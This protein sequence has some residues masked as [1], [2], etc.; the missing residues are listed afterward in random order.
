MAGGFVML[1]GGLV[2]LGWTGGWTTLIRPL[3][4]MVGM[5]PLT[6]LLLVFCGFSLWRLS[7]SPTASKRD[8]LNLGLAGAV[9]V[10]G[11][12]RSA[13]YL[14][15]FN[16]HLEQ[17]LFAKRVAALASSLPSE[18]AP[19]T[20]VNLLLCGVALL[21]L[22]VETPRR[23]WFAQ[24]LVLLSGMVALLALIGYTY[25][26]LVFYQVGLAIPMSLETAV[27]FAALCLGFLA[28]RPVGGFMIVVT[29][30][31]TGGTVIRRLLP[32]A[33]FAPWILGALLL[34]GEQAGRFTWDIGLSI[35][36]VANIVIF[37][38]LI[39]WNAKLLFLADLERARAEQRRAVQHNATRVL[40]EASD[41]REATPRLLQTICE[42]L[43]WQGAALWMVDAPSNTLRCVEFWHSPS[44]PLD[45]F[46]E[47]SRKSA[48]AR[49]VG[50]PGRV[51]A[52]GRP[53]WIAD[54]AADSS[55]PRLPL[56]IR[57]G[58]HGVLGFPI[59]LGQQMLGVMEFHSQD[60]EP[61]REALLEVFAALGVQLG[62]FIERTT[63]QEQLRRTSAD[64]HRSNA[65]LQ[66]FAHI[67]S[68]DLFEPLRM[69]TSYLQLLSEH[70]RASLDPQ[71]SEFIG[72]AVDGAQRMQALIHDLLEYA[73]VEGRAHAFQ[74]VDCT[75]A[76][77]AAIAN[78]KVALEE[79]GAVVFHE[80]LPWA[81]ADG[82]QITR[83][84]QNL[85]GN[86]IKFRGPKPPRVEAG[87]DR[88]EGEWIFFV[89]DN[90]M[91]IDPKNFNR[92]F[93]IFQRLHTR[94]E[95]P[96]TGMGLAIC[97]RI[98]E[99]HGGRIWVESSL[100]HGATFFF[101]L[102]SLPESSIRSPSAAS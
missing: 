90:G 25:R 6:A 8:W 75:S 39:W 97:K 38:A 13:D 31:T 96:G 30:A 58:L 33:I 84:F 42:T 89:R 5:N 72:F 41:L 70:C 77:N 44:V 68:H 37:S 26:I 95:Y 51:W 28:A 80:T 43:R 81:N 9:T 10:V 76:F 11:A 55:L 87:A 49:G 71:A 56:A 82:V 2:L 98:V 16:F 20:A 67:A 66:Q 92:I 4:T 100:G 35:F 86:A 60:T 48:F 91:G 46:G 65:E 14:F 101:T 17:L 59:R 34:L 1:V 40:V 47:A 63:A 57:A 54:A 99:R 88:R 36:A 52:A 74:P 78:L 27:A 45:E 24:A 15:H 94:Q 21:L 50:L 85:I 32:V 18:M 7:A 29:S 22:N 61:P 3:P 12:L 53:I 79:A 64:L 73:R 62:L 69:V 19:N 93:D 23:L 83:L 102:P